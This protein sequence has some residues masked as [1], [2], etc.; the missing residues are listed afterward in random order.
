MKES[1]RIPLSRDQ[2]RV[3]GEL[4]RRG[5]DE[6]PALDLSPEGLSLRLHRLD[7]MQDDLSRATK[8][9][10]EAEING[11]PITPRIAFDEESFNLFYELAMTDLSTIDKGD[12]DIIRELRLAAFTAQERLRGATVGTVF[13]LYNL[14]ATKEELHLFE[15]L[16][17]HER[18]WIATG[19]AIGSITEED[20]ARQT[21]RLDRLF[22]HLTTTVRKPRRVDRDPT[23]PEEDI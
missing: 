6:A 2:R 14:T 4:L 11:K 12:H 15:T 8:R 16:I 1:I 10:L 7:R 13:D 9:A 3:Y 23:P 19:R 5:R 21:A 20:A 22:R 17:E 18:S